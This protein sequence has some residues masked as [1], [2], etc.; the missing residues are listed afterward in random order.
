MININFRGRLNSWWAWL[1]VLVW[2]WER[3]CLCSWSR[4]P[5]VCDTKSVLTVSTVGA[6][7]RTTRNIDSC[8]LVTLASGL[9]EASTGLHIAPWSSQIEHPE[10]LLLLLLLAV[11]SRMTPHAT[12]RFLPIYMKKSC[13]DY[14]EAVRKFIST[15]SRAIIAYPIQ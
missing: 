10:L 7:E 6:V 15:Q 1:E 14:S 12:L 8:A 13:R 11:Q 4:H 3:V 2:D 5:V 9:R